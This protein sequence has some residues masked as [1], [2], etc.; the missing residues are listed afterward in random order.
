MQL[1]ENPLDRSSPWKKE[2]KNRKENLFTLEQESGKGPNELPDF[3][4]V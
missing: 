4:S 2:K 3:T 1:L